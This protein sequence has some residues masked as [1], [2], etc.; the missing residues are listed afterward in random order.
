MIHDLKLTEN[1]AE[2]LLEVL[3]IQQRQLTHEIG[4]TDALRAK[5]ELRK[6]ERAIDRLV[7]RVRAQVAAENQTA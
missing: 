1:E 6:R 7:E 5:G 2:L 4:A 3:E